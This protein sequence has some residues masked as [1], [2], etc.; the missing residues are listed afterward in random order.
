MSNLRKK[1]RS[2][3]KEEYSNLPTGHF[4]DGGLGIEYSGYDIDGDNI[5]IYTTNFD[6]FEITTDDLIEYL[7]Q[8]NKLENILS[9]YVSSHSQDL[10]HKSKSDV[11]PFDSIDR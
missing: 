1:I 10:N 7:M 3:I 2:L 4:E 5:S 6:P 11:D 8:T 9:S